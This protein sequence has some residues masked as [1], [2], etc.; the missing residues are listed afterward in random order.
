MKFAPESIALH[1]PATASGGRRRGEE[2]EDALGVVERSDMDGMV[3][4]E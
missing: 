2:E 1:V 4:A 3:F